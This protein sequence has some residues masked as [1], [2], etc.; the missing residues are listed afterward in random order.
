MLPE[1][2]TEKI[3]LEAIYYH[4][5]TKSNESKKKLDDILLLYASKIKNSQSIDNIFSNLHI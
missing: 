3:V 4:S 5:K 2:I 1:E